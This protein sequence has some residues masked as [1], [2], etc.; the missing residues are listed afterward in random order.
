M[1]WISPTS[2]IVREGLASNM[3]SCEGVKSR[4]G[5]SHT[6]LSS[7]WPQNIK[8]NRTPQR[9]MDYLSMSLSESGTGWS[10]S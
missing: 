9:M 5:V 7:N 2:Y 4:L 10:S 3:R 1:I 6:S 8:L